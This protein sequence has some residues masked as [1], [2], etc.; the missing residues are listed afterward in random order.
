MGE[1]QGEV[2]GKRAQSSPGASLSQ[3][4]RVFTG[5]KLLEPRPLGLLRRLLCVG[6]ADQTAGRW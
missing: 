5:W 2:C 4:L 1:V 3:G 6:A